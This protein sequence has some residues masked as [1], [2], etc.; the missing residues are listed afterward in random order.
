ML[1]TC[2]PGG[3]GAGR[4]GL[5]LR[6]LRSTGRC[7]GGPQSLR[8]EEVSRTRLH[9]PCD[10][11]DCTPSQHGRTL[12]QRTGEPRL[13]GCSSEGERTRE[14]VQTSVKQKLSNFCFHHN[15]QSEKDT[16]LGT[17]YACAHPRAHAHTRMCARSISETQASG[18]TLASFST[19]GSP[20]PPL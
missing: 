2:G 11:T 13:H 15:L 4:G 17:Q 3:L 1:G 8:A 19:S 6:G 12:R 18:L 16:L 20:V 14:Q 7:S 10:H 9:R 5:S